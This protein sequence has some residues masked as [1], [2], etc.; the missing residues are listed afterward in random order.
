MESFLYTE[1]NIF[2]FVILLLIFLNVHHQ[3]VTYFNEQKLFLALLFSN[4]LILIF[5]TFMW[6]LDGKPGYNNYIVLS[7]VTTIYYI[8]NPVIC[9]VWSIYADYQIHQDDNRNSKLIRILLVPIIIFTIFA[10]LSNYNRSLFYIDSQNRY[11]RGVY[12]LLMA[13]ICYAYLMYT[14]ISIIYSQK[15]VKNEKFLP[16][17]IF[18]FPPVIGGFIQFA[19]YGISI[20][21]ICMTVSILIVFINIQNDLVYKDYLTDLYNRRQ[22]D[23]YLKEKIDKNN[24]K[25]LLTGIMIDLNYF[26]KINDQYG[27]S[28]GDDALRYIANILKKTFQKNAFLS[29]YGGDEFIVILEVKEKAELYQHIDRLI[30]SIN[31]FNDKKLAPYL[32]NISFGADFYDVESN[33]T[34]YEFLNYIDQLMYLDKENNHL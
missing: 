22:L 18:A 23:Q 1:L 31:T 8:L 28:A 33:M 20:I 34:A 29:R 7:V 10:I 15:K 5:D 27:H 25:G 17:L 12:F 26:K 9:M 16:I 32:L 19:Y 24:R 6:I 21:W 11:H 2:A 13:I 30:E 4:A 3:T 14:L